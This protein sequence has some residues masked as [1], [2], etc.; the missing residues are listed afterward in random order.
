MTQQRSEQIDAVTVADRLHKVKRA[1]V[2]T[3]LG[4]ACMKMPKAVY[5][6]LA[7]FAATV[8]L[9]ALISF[10]VG[11]VIAHQGY[12]RIA[13]ATPAATSRLIRQKE[14]AHF[15]NRVSDAFGIQGSVANEFADWILEASERQGIKPELLASLVVTESS[16]RKTAQS[17]VGAIGPA[18]VRPEYWGEFC[19][20]RGQLHDPEQNVYCG[21]QIL[22]HMLDRCEGDMNCALA[23]YNVGPYARDHRIEA[24]NRYVQKIDRYLTSLEAPGIEA[25]PA[26]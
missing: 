19:G 12:E 1:V 6:S 7:G 13:F 17:H 4:Q 8:G 24:A 15:G 5:L 25:N 26:L 23:A 20:A 18:Q 16:F 11:N 21:A 10:S 2:K 9:L 3:A 14:V 22:S